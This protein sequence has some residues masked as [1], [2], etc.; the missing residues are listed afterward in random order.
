[1]CEKGISWGFFNDHGTQ[2]HSNAHLNNFI[3][4]KPKIWEENSSFFLL[5]L[6]YDLAYTKDEFI[7]IE[8]E[9]ENYGC[10][11]ENMF[12]NYMCAEYNAMEMSLF[13]LQLM[14]FT[15]GIDN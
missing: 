9:S 10:F 7:N 6:D 5:P 14:D 2:W 12:E 4:T 11:D 3:V 15:Y 8:L 13:G 1:M